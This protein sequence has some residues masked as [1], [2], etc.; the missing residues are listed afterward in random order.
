HYYGGF[1]LLAHGAYLILARPGL[2]TWKRWLLSM[3]AIGAIFIPW[4]PGFLAQFFN[5]WL[6]PD[7][8]PGT[9]DLWTIIQRL[10][11]SFSFGAAASSPVLLL[12]LGAVFL[13]ALVI[14]W[15]RRQREVGASGELFLLL[16][17]LVPVLIVYAI[18]AQN[19]KF[20]E[21]YLLIVTTPFYL[22][23]A[24]GLGAALA[25]RHGVGIVG[26]WVAGAALAGFLSA[27][28]VGVWQVYTSPAYAKDDHRGAIAYITERSQP[29]DVILLVRDTYQS[30]QYYYRGDLPWAGIDPGPSLA[31]AAEQLREATT[32]HQ[33]VWTLLWQDH[34]VDPTGAVVGLLQREGLELPIEHS[35][36]GVRLRLFTLPANPRFDGLPAQP[37]PA[38]FGGQI[39]LLGYDLK[40]SITAGGEV[41]VALYWRL[42]EEVKE[43]LQLHLAVKDAAGQEWG[44]VD[45]RPAGY[46]LPTQRW[47]ADTVIRGTVDIP[48]APGAP[49]GEYHLEAALYPV[50]SLQDLPVARPGV[51][52]PS[53]RL[54]FG[55]LQ[56][57]RPS[58]PLSLGALG[59]AEPQEVAFGPPDGREP[60]LRLL[61][62]G[63]IGGAVQPGQSL[64]IS[65]FWETTSPLTNDYAIILR[66]VDQNG[67][68]DA[69]TRSP[70]IPGYPASQWSVSDPL[71]GRY[72]LVPRAQASPGPHQLQLLVEGLVPSGSAREQNSVTIGQVNLLERPRLLTEPNIAYRQPALLG[73]EIAFLGYD[74][75][76]PASGVSSGATVPI[77]LYWRADS[78]MDRSY[79]VFVHLLAADGH[80]V[81]QSDGVPAEWSLPTTAWLLGE[82]VIDRHQLAIPSTTASGSY[83]IVVG[84]YNAETGQRLSISPPSEALTEDR[85]IL[86][87]AVVTV[88]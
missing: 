38:L 24:R 68:I 9:L 1:L 86:K 37:L 28:L 66:L 15:L 12:A 6:H 63:P 64:P 67:K 35:F 55:S 59:I 75:A 53:P 3:G 14:A 52:T 83:Q 17:L 49:P 34:V 87:N 21:R 22:L 41:N 32:G 46:W 44:L 10:F 8:W 2:G 58:T 18:S 39:E 5:L 88:R 62:R 80:L 65:L 85:L 73:G 7:Y 57:E 61:G 4:L 36:S 47:P 40:G 81:T 45:A 26:R 69:E 51:A 30:F 43:D 33:R 84:M 19:P 72:T 74:L 82:Y 23:L 25:W 48:I 60:V 77:T 11:A 71:E 76:L 42:R 27:S 20:A 78:E 56:V 54:T 29:G 79:K 31:N 70:T 50:A 16:Y 13:A